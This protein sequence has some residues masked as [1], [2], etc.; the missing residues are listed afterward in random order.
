MGAVDLIFC[1]YGCPLFH[2]HPCLF[3]TG[4]DMEHRTCILQEFSTLFCSLVVSL[5]LR[6]NTEILNFYWKGRPLVR[7]LAFC[8]KRSLLDLFSTEKTEYN[9]TE[10][11]LSLNLS[12][13]RIY[14]KKVLEMRG[15]ALKGEVSLYFFNS[16]SPPLL[17]SC[18]STHYPFR[19]DL[20]TE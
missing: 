7:S 10:Y 15:H 4:L 11:I 9:N 3:N 16:L 13:S 19:R 8:P 17:F 20:R 18:F 2:F 5:S 6:K 12:L 14:F 1:V